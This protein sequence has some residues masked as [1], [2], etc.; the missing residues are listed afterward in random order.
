[1]NK[2]VFTNNHLHYKIFH[3]SERFE[4]L[5]HFIILQG[6]DIRYVKGNNT[7]YSFSYHNTALNVPVI[8]INIE[9]KKAKSVQFRQMLI[10]LEVAH[11][12]NDYHYKL[13]KATNQQHQYR[14]MLM[15]T[16]KTSFNLLHTTS[17]H[18]IKNDPC[19]NLAMS[20]LIPDDKAEKLM[21]NV[22]THHIKF[23]H[24]LRILTTQY[25]TDVLLTK[26]W[27]KR[28]LKEIYQTKVQK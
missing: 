17:K 13:G 5:D 26:V 23:N 1:M 16:N 9:P 28:L 27:L 6:I 21:L 24:A 12:I 10:A 7:L 4:L 11:L 22:A 2:Q 3:R 18:S 8:D 25:H 20:I 15:K 19:F 14:R